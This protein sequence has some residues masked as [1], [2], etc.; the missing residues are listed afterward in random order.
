MVRQEACGLPWHGRPRG[1]AICAAVNAIAFIRDADIDGLR[2]IAGSSGS[3]IESHPDDADDVAGVGTARV[4]NVGSRNGEAGDSGPGRAEISAPPEAVAAAGA[5]IESAVAVGINSQAL[6]HRPARHVAAD[7]ERQI[8]ALKSIAPVRGAK[9][10]AVLSC[11]FVSVSAG[12]DVKAGGVYRIGGEAVNARQVP[13]VEAHP[14]EQWNP[15]TRALIPSIG[16]ADVGAGV[17]QIL[18]GRVEDDA[19]NE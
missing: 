11:K 1:A 19:W 17:N 14:I 9:D 15:T 5:E 8:R 4:L 2:R 10:G 16:A 6:A 18:F 7:F 13:I 12:G 3:A